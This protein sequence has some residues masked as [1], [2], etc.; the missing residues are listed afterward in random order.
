LP[1]DLRELYVRKVFFADGSDEQY[2]KLIE[3]AK[4]GSVLAKDDEEA[5]RWL[6]A[7]AARADAAR[8]L[9]KLPQPIV[10][11][12]RMLLMNGTVGTGMN[13]SRATA[14]KARG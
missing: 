2:A 1:V 7:F 3:D 8:V 12:L 13:V 6:A 10:D 5:A 11:R 14:S 4:A 9:A